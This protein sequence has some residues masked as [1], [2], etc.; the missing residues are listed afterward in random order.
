[1]KL[2]NDIEVKLTL[3][4]PQT[5]Y[6]KLT[7]KYP[8]F[9]AGFGSGKSQIM[10]VDAV[11]DSMEGGSDSLVALYEPT[12]DLVRLIL[13]PRMQQVLSDFGVAYK[14]NKSENIIYTSSSQ[15]GD[16][17][18]RTL[19]NPARIVGY[20]S[21]RAKIDE[22]DTLKK[23]HARDAFNKIIARNRQKPTTYN[24]ISDKPMNTVGVFSTPEG[25]RFVYE[26]WKKAPTA[27]YKMIQASTRS[28]PFIPDDYIDSLFETYPEELI[29]AY[30]DGQFVN[31]TS[32]V[33]FNAYNRVKHRSDETIQPK[34]LLKIGMD[35]N[36]GNMSAVVYVMRGK[37]WHAVDEL[38]G[39]YDTPAIID[40]IHERYPEHSIRVYPDA[41]GGSRKS[42]DASKSDIS[43]L[44]SAGFNI[45]AKSKNPFVKDRVMATNNAFNKELLYI[46]DTKC[47]ET[48][49][50]F[51]QL[52]YDKNGAPDKTSNLDHLTDAG[53]YPIAYELQITRPAMTGLN[54]GF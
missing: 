25:F 30:I 36:V 39:V 48:A 8:A 41:S 27:S 20:E 10:C 34:E 38:K 4:Q 49:L 16:F 6:L 12:Y 40:I 35:F 15:F 1:L 19:D 51:E 7:C 5:D 42:V 3:T 45:R 22:L 17:V 33:V 9:V 13:A 28:N 21:F 54:I 53:T 26:K 43:L 23:E 46:N 50:C 11:L 44:R 24:K 29:S 18:L 31:L 52:A 47:P 14:Y 32:G 2:P 37:Q